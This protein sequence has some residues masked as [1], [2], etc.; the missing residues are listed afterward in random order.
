[1]DNGSFTALVSLDI[2]A[3][4]DAL[5]HSVLSSRLQSDFILALTELHWTGFIRIS[6]ADIRSGRPF[7]LLSTAM[8]CGC[9]TGQ[10]ARTS[11][12]YGLHL[13]DWPR[14]WWT[15]RQVP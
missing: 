14:G 6:V 5:N 2:S 13:A 12:I 3:A 9:P 15:W 1:M 4:F 10:R 8:H 7:G 11:T